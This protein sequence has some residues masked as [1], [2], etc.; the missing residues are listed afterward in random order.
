MDK[1]LQE[2]IFKDVETYRV[3]TVATLVD[4]FKINGSLARKI[5][6]ELEESGKI[7]RVIGNHRCKVWTRKVAAE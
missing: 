2:K 6:R 3:L 7:L 1:A 5:L 4:R